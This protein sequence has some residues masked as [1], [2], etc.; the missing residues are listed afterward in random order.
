MWAQ[1][2][3]KSV[4]IVSKKKNFA[5][6][7]IQNSSN[8]DSYQTAQMGRLIWILAERTYWKLGFLTLLLISVL[9]T[10][11]GPVVQN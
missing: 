11:Q 2:R 5:S 1:Q 8:E 4:F 3:I 7:A 9:S 6:L 10:I